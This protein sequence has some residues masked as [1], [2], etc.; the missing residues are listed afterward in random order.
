MV[1]VPL[2]SEAGTP[3]L[4]VEGPSGWSHISDMRETETCGKCGAV[5]EVI[6]RRYLLAGDKDSFACRL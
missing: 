2:K 6:E 5:Y 4:G 3:S 1:A